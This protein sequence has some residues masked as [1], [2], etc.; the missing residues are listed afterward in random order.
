MSRF[1]PALIIVDLQEDFLPPDGSLAVQNAREIIPIINQLTDKSIY[2]WSVVIASKDWHPK[3]HCSFASNNPGSKPFDV[4]KFHNPEN[5]EITMDQVVWPDHCIQNEK[6]SEF[7]EEFQTE[8]RVD[9]LVLKGYL[10][11]REYYSAFADAWSLHHTELN[12]ILQ[13]QGITDVIVCGLAYDYC[14]MN[15]CIDAAKNGYKTYVLKDVSKAV[16]PSKIDTDVLAQY[17][18]GG[19]E[20]IGLDSKVMKRVKTLSQ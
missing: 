16:D 18:K 11:D 9:Q 15:T 12:D 13:N 7:P 1:N 8:N 14:V 10:S 20:I 17:T 3:N 6:G 2:H 4:L 19:V 5:P